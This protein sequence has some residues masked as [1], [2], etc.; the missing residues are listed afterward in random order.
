[1]QD[2]RVCDHAYRHSAC[3][4]YGRSP[5]SKKLYPFFRFHLLANGGTAY[6]PFL[7]KA[8]T[9]IMTV[10]ITDY[11]FLYYEKARE[12]LTGW[13]AIMLCFRCIRE[14]FIC[15]QTTFFFLNTQ[16]TETLLYF[17]MLCRDEQRVMGTREEVEKKQFI[18]LIKRNLHLAQRLSKLT[19]KYLNQ[20]TRAFGFYSCV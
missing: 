3:Q 8:V 18:V 10:A 9:G 16:D 12:N 2:S 7:G 14:V 20:L 15:M 4:P 5:Q 19:R 17:K 1:M 6:W 11:S 13:T